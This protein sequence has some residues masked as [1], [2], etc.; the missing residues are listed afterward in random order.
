MRLM[1]C[2]R[3]EILSDAAVAP[4]MRQIP[5][6][7]QRDGFGGFSL[8]DEEQT[9]GKG[10]FLVYSLIR[11]GRAGSYLIPCIQ[12][13]RR[14]ADAVMNQRRSLPFRPCHTGPLRAVKGR[15]VEKGHGH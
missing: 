8:M 9:W 5:V 14:E 2:G 15:T 10:V 6:S 1:P 3:L 7:S 11:P 13:K 4:G 12:G